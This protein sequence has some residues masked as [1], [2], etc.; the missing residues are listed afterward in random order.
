MARTISSP[1]NDVPAA[2][3]A[4][5]TATDMA[6]AAHALMG[7]GDRGAAEA[8]LEMA[9]HNRILALKLRVGSGLRR[10]RM[11][12]QRGEASAS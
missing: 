10:D 2:L 6:R 9:R 3:L 7:L 1:S 11:R 4:D 8:L 12:S 5:A